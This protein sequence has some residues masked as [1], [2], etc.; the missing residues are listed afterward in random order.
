[1]KEDVNLIAKSIFKSNNIRPTRIR[2]QVFAVLYKSK[3]SFSLLEMHEHFNREKDRI[4]L[5]RALQKICSS[6]SA[7]SFIDLSGILRYAYLDKDNYKSPIFLCT[8]CNSVKIL[9]LLPLDY[10]LKI[11]SETSISQTPLTIFG[12]CKNC[13]H[14]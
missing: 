13:Q 10:T 14:R 9:P 7:K 8:S 12:K 2:L 11:E 3:K 5:Y 6:N 1:M 4:S